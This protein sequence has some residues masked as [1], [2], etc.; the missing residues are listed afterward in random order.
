M[1]K[2]SRKASSPT[3]VLITGASSGLGE[4]M[5]RQYASR[6]DHLALISRRE[7]CLSSLSEELRQ[8]SPGSK[9]FWKAADVTDIASLHQAMNELREQSGGID[10][11]IANAGIATRNRIGSGH[12]S[13][14]I[15]VFR[16]NIEGAVATLDQAT[17]WFRQSGRG[18]LV[19]ISS[20]AAMRGM[21]SFGAYC[22]SKAALASYMQA[23]RAELYDTDIHC[24][25]LFPGYIDTPLNNMM[26]SRPFLVDSE[27]GARLMLELIDRK[28]AES[29]VPV[30]PWKVIASLLRWAPDSIIA[31][32]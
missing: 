4:A 13:E 14:D 23:L 12:L 18:H 8:K 11:V 1:A 7:E 19:A 9:V 30:K 2:N 25:T 22:A 26:T 24:T 20:V 31:R 16:T 6:G 28:V 10:R 17:S 27:K 15:H 21:P 32:Q 29:T 3:T 5:A